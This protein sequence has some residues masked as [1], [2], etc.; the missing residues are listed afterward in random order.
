[1]PDEVKDRVHALAH[2]A[3]ASRGL[4]FTD[5]DGTDLDEL[6]PD[7]NNTNDNSSDDDDSDDS[8]YDPNDI[9]D[10]NDSDNESNDSDDSDSDDDS[11]Y[12]PSIN[13]DDEKSTDSYDLPGATPPDQPLPPPTSVEPG[14]VNNTGNDNSR[15]VGVA[16]NTDR[17]VGVATETNENDITYLEA[18]VNKLETELDNEI[19]AIDSNYNQQDSEESDDETNGSFEPMEE[20]E[21]D[22]LHADAT[23]EQSSD[24]AEMPALHN[25]GSDDDDSDDDP[26]DDSDDDAPEEPLSRLRRKRGTNT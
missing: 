8:T 22:E 17:N 20:D 26:D 16:T 15:N 9:E 14:G 4:T 6:Y 2:R 21:A 18:Y 10:N 3:H 12:S 19:A 5:S 24:D 25:R 11:D 7:D 1:M 13:S 23:C